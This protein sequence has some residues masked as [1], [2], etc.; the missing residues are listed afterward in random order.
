M[1]DEKSV[2]R[3]ASP[4]RRRAV[5]GT[6]AASA[7]LAGCGLDGEAQPQ[8]ARAPVTIRI[9]TRAG[10]TGHT[11]WYQNVTP[12]AFQPRFPHV[13][14]EW[15][16]AAGTTVTEKLVT[17]GASGT[18]PDVSWLGLISDGGRAGLQRNLFRPLDPFV[19]ADKFD[20]SVYWTALLDPM[21]LRGQLFGLPTHGHFGPVIAYVNTELVKR[22]GL[23]IPLADGNWTLDEM[24]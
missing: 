3:R 7:V 2:V 23:Q 6:A 12:R 22:A 18:L 1:N 10:P 16:E 4:A 14:V 9:L 24:I 5:L 8:A 21:S 15:D 11:G 19:K 20:K 13:T 17:F